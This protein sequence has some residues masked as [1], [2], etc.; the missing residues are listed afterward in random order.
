MKKALLIFAAIFL[1]LPGIAGGDFYTQV[2][3]VNIASLTDGFNSGV[4]G[5]SGA[6]IYVVDL[7]K[8][9]QYQGDIMLQIAGVSTDGTR[10][11]DPATGITVYYAS[12]LDADATDSGDTAWTRADWKLL[13]WNHLIEGG[14]TGYPIA[15]PSSVTMSATPYLGIK[16][17]QD[18]G[19]DYGTGGSPFVIDLRGAV[20]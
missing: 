10:P 5:E 4:T 20:H 17:F 8:Y 16:V 11:A 12:S 18:T 15:I 2:R 1:V 6:S 3:T 13:V 7:T 19:A 14:P 9:R